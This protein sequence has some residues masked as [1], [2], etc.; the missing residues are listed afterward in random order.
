MSYDTVATFSQVAS[1]LLFVALFFAVL[2]YV[3]W[4]GNRKRFEKAQRSA[5]HLDEKANG[6]KRR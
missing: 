4:P 1:L 3:F 2:A 6:N 5:L